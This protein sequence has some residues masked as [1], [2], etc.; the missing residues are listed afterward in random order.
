M[1]LNRTCDAHD[2][3]HGPGLPDEPLRAH[4]LAMAVRAAEATLSG[5]G[6][7]DTERS[8]EIIHVAIEDVWDAPDAELN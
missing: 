3:Q 8:L 1:T 7:T 2:V 5:H 6:Y 4:V